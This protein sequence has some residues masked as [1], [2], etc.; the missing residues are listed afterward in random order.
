M[1]APTLRKKF[2]I[3]TAVLIVL[4]GCAFSLLV[5]HELHV[6]FEDEVHK[7][8]LSIARYIQRLPKFP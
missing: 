4:V 1:P 8:G 7:R 6:R 3:G 5:S 2:I